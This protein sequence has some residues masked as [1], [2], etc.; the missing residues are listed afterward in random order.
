MND[1]TF[2][3]SLI[4]LGIVWVALGLFIYIVRKED[5][6]REQQY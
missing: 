4:L 3:T 6:K 2:I 1:V 5:K